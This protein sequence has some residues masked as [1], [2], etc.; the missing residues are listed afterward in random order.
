MQCTVSRLGWSSECF[1]WLSRVNSGTWFSLA[2]LE[3]V[4]GTFI[5]RLCA[6]FC[7]LLFFTFFFESVKIL[8]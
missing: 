2:K 8:F 1:S 5:C 4:S 6:L 3:R 7:F